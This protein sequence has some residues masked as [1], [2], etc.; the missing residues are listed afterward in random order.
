MT[1][2][3]ALQVLLIGEFPL[4]L[5][6]TP[7]LSCFSISKIYLLLL[8]VYGCLPNMY[9][10]DA[11]PMEVRRGNWIPQNWSYRW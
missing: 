1:F 7:Y 11:V 8:Y 2:V 6:S 3:I 9:V 4:V 5:W 10:Y